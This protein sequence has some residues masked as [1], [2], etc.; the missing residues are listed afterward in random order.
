MVSELRELE[1]AATRGPWSSQHDFTGEIAYVKRMYQDDQ[2]R[3]V[4]TVI[5][6]CEGYG[7]NR[8]ED[9]ALIAALRNAAPYLLA[10]V[11]AAQELCDW[12]DNA[13]IA[14]AEFALADAMATL[15]EHLRGER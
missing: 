2:D 11:E 7:A 4:H 1:K 9:A 6:R 15:G 8:T 14:E 5:A 13:T 3:R 12:W 10:V